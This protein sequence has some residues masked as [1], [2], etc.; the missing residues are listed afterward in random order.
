MM[1]SNHPQKLEN[2]SPGKHYALK[3]IQINVW[4]SKPITDE[5]HE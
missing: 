2:T 5:E 4:K 3:S 1:W